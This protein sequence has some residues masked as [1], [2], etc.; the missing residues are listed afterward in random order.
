MKHH[1]RND[2]QDFDVLSNGMLFKERRKAYYH[3]KYHKRMVSLFI[4]MTVLAA[5]LANH[6]F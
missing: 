1:D 3:G 5:L 6:Q 2:N 4:L